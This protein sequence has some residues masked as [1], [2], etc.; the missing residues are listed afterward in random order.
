MSDPKHAATPQ[1]IASFTPQR[2]RWTY[3]IGAA[4]IALLIAYGALDSVKAPLWL[5]L[6]GTILGAGAVDMHIPTGGEK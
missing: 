6:I 1:P 4:V 3:R 5:A 2:R